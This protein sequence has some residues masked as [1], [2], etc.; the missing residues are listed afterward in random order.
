M[1]C[2]CGA[3]LEAGDDVVVRHIFFFLKYATFARPRIPLANGDQSNQKGNARAE[4]HNPA[5]SPPPN[6]AMLAERPMPRPMSGRPQSLLGTVPSRGVGN[7]LTTEIT[8]EARDR[9]KVR[10]E[11][12]PTTPEIGEGGG[13]TDQRLRQVVR[14]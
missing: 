11:A 7:A 9:R 2:G 1:R 6:T 3:G 14:S 12:G 4:R 10:E 5:M 8:V 13:M